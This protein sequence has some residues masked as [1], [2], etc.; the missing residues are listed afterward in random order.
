MYRRV[1]ASAYAKCLQFLSKV[2]VQEANANYC[3]P[4][5][6]HGPE[7]LV[8]KPL[9][10]AFHFTYV[11]S[12]QMLLEIDNL[13]I[14]SCCNLLP[15]ASLQWLNSDKQMRVP[16]LKQQESSSIITAKVNTGVP[17]KPCKNLFVYH[18]YALPKPRFSKSP[19]YHFLCLQGYS[20][21][22]YWCSSL[23]GD[24]ANHGWYLISVIP[25]S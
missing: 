15:S 13:S 8:I 25:Q 22:P 21:A 24:D 19:K 6:R 16:A 1:P 14:S 9:T 5:I 18:S 4:D 11:F 23:S 10:F 20:S 3:L 17:I 2:T 12:I 7:D